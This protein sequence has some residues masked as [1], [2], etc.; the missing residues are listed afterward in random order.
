M[1]KLQILATCFV[2]RI[3]NGALNN[4]SVTT[5]GGT[6][7]GLNS[8]PTWKLSNVLTSP[9]TWLGIGTAIYNR[10]PGLPQRSKVGKFAAPMIIAGIAALLDD[11]VSTGYS[12][13]APPT[14]SGYA[15]TSPIALP[16][17]STG[18]VR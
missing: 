14:G 15:V 13:V 7:S 5:S 11:P 3:T 18:Y 2:E 4:Q 16:N 17:N 6:V 8:K 9:F 12:G 1:G 10:V